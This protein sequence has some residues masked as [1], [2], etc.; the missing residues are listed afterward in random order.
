[1][2]QIHG[3]KRL[4]MLY[5]DAIRHAYK[6]QSTG[7][8]YIS[9]SQLLS[10]YKKPFDSV[11]AAERVAKREGKN[12]DEVLLEW[13]RLNVESQEYGT[14][15]HKVIEDFHKNGTVESGYESL[16]ESYKSLSIIDIE[17]DVL[18]NEERLWLHEYKLA[19][20]SDIIRTEDKGGFSVF[21]IKTNKKF[22]FFSQYNE[23][24]L[25]PL[26][27]LTACEF[28]TYS[29][30]ISLYA[31][32]YQNLTGRHVNQL[33]VFYY[34]RNQNKFQYY[35]VIYMKADVKRLLEHYE[36]SNVG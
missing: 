35:P 32:M 7:D 29:L 22:N 21:D 30:Q 12:V 31:Y 17:E 15:I 20:T 10:K 34:D 13:K 24:L 14:A 16:I 9:V 19:G 18:L 25:Y 11:K 1:M 27:H 33:G 5:F 36:Q 6:N 28:T 26:N 4:N 3:K 23:K 8:E 2:K